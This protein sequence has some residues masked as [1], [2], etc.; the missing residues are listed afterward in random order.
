M[1][2]YM[3]VSIVIA[4]MAY[5]AAGWPAGLSAVGTTVLVFFAGAALRGSFFPETPKLQ[6]LAVFAA[7]IIFLALAHWIGKG[8]SV[9]LARWVFTG[10]QWGWIGFI[11]CFTCTTKRFAPY[12]TP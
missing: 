8:F 11:I 2:I 10:S 12:Q 6:K 3:I 9:H 4:V 7:A 1:Y 5:N